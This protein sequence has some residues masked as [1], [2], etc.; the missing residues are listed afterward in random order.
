MR[1]PAA[2]RANRRRWG[3][4]AGAASLGQRSAGGCA[5]RSRA[6]GM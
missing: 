1:D 3:D 2:D 4:L 5:S 6:A